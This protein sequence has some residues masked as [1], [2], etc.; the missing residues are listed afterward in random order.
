M[1]VRL[2]GGRAG[3]RMLRVPGASRRSA[4]VAGREGCGGRAQGGRM[5]LP[6]KDLGVQPGH[7]RVPTARRDR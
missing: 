1:R 7:V 4:A 5:P 6:Q 3:H 2:E